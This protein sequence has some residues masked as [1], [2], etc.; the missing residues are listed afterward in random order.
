MWCEIFREG[1]WG[2]LNGFRAAGTP[3]LE[4]RLEVAEEEEEEEEDVEEGKGGGGAAMAA[5]RTRHSRRKHAQ[6]LVMG[7]TVVSVG[8][9]VS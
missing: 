1:R 3:V 2:L 7:D 4:R 5:T 6:L 9:R 8:R